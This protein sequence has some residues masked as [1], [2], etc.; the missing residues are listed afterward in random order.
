MKTL[1]ESIQ[2]KIKGDKMVSP[3]AVDDMQGIGKRKTLYPLFDY[4]FTV[5]SV[6][7][8]FCITCSACQQE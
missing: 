3:L 5:S 1:T 7:C 2:S 8:T 4:Y 6:W